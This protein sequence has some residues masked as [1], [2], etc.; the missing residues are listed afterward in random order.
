MDAGRS[1]H[2]LAPRADRRAVED[3]ETDR[4][5]L[6]RRLRSRRLRRRIGQTEYLTSAQHVVS[7]FRRTT[8]QPDLRPFRIA[9][10][11]RYRSSSLVRPLI[12]TAFASVI[13]PQFISRRK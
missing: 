12:A 11:H 1:A 3:P 10:N 2:R 13:A 8:L 7:A 9:A 5:G 4:E 6:S